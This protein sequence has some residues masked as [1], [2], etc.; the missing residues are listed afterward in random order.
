M[1]MIQLIINIIIT[2]FFSI[3]FVL[4][5]KHFL[6]NLFS[7][8]KS[9]NIFVIYWFDYTFILLIIIILLFFKIR[10]L[11][12]YNSDFLDNI[13]NKI[14]V[15]YPLVYANQFLLNIISSIQFLLILKKARNKQLTNFIIEIYDISLYFIEQLVIIIIEGS[16]IFY[17]YSVSQKKDK[18]IFIIINIFRISLIIISIIMSFFVSK[19]YKNFRGYHKHF[20]GHNNIE[21]K[22]YEKN[23]KKVFMLAEHY[24][25]KIICDFLLNIPSIIFFVNIKFIN[26]IN[27]ILEK[28]KNDENILTSLYYY[29]NIFFGFLYFYIFG[30]M[31]LNIDYKTEGYIEKIFNFFFCTKKY[32]F[33]FGNDKTSKNTEDLY[34]KKAIVDRFNYNSYFQNESIN[35]LN[36]T[37]KET[38]LDTFD[39]SDNDYNE[40]EEEES[41][42]SNEKFEVKSNN[43]NL[44]YEYSPCNFYFLYK[45]LYLFFQI[46]KNLFLELEKNEEI[47][48]SRIENNDSSSK[49]ENM[50]R[51]Q[52]IS[53]VFSNQSDEE[54]KKRSKNNSF[55]QKNIK[56]RA[57]N[58]N[59]RDHSDL[60]IIN[61][62]EKIENISKVSS[63]NKPRFIVSKKYTLDELAN[64]FEDQ[65]MKRYF[66]KN[67]CPKLNNNFKSTISSNT[68]STIKEKDE[69]LYTSSADVNYISKNKLGS[70]NKNLT[71][72]KDIKFKIKSLTN[73][74][75]FDINPYYNLKI[76][77]IIKSLDL[78]NNMELFYK[79][80]EE[81]LKNE[82]YNYYYTKD[83]LLSIEIYDEAFFNSYQLKTFI[84]SYKNYLLDKITNFSY[85]FLPLIIE[86]FNIKYLSYNKIVVLSRNPL[87]FSYN[88]NC[89]FWLKFSYHEKVEIEKSTDKKDLIDLGEIEDNIILE[90]NEYKNSVQVLDN[91]LLFLQNNIKYN[92]N[93]KLNLFVLNDEYKN[94]FFYISQS[95]KSSANPTLNDINNNFLDKI[96]GDS[97]ISFPCE[98]YKKYICQKK[99]FG[100]YDICLLEKLY[101]NELVNNRYI[102]KIYFSDIFKKR[103]VDDEDKSK[104]N[105]SKTDS[106]DNLNSSSNTENDDEEEEIFTTSNNSKYCELLKKKLIR[107]INNTSNSFE[108]EI[109]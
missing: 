53:S 68:F 47:N 72:E 66:I 28:K 57:S 59:L 22:K 16:I 3:I 67:I 35:T 101:V 7:K 65:K 13:R 24:F 80:S 2:A 14:I 64:N 48:A 71:I 91:D 81:K 27:D 73:D 82:S 109:K 61:I 51:S 106:Y 92:F 78:K 54:K 1:E 108:E 88:M 99:Y 46:N 45:L 49:N 6:V 19:R 58:V 44:E 56:R 29:L 33:Y 18:D 100:S 103:I 74:I 95:I 8:K 94:D 104:Q 43:K 85:S 105:N 102:F 21:Q 37:A 5:V 55:I 63:I 93:F 42:E 39:S 4:L 107:N 86:I 32:D 52:I 30:I 75:L 84:E 96:M 69:S 15:Y 60:N 12:N 62:K 83:T 17:L 98:E 20:D 38:F 41:E 76:K 87:S 89:H 23:R 11:I 50:D 70:K 97:L 10:E 90:N 25:Y 9:N 34:N 36:K 77:D 31:L 40:E 79:F 26:I